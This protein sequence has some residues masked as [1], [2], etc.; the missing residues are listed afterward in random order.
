MYDTSSIPESGNA[1]EPGYCPDPVQ[2]ADATDSASPPQNSAPEPSGETVD[3]PTRETHELLENFPP[4]IATLLI[5]S[6]IAGILL[7]G[8]VGA[9]MLIAGGVVMWPRTFRP[10]ERWFSKKFP[11]VHRDGVIQLKEFVQNLEKRFPE[12]KP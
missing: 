9:P 11:S 12:K 7:P 8:P 10:I 6:G 5:M 3:D 4:E 1:L 2:S